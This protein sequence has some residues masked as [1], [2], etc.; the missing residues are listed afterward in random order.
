MLGEFLR[1]NSFNMRSGVVF[2]L[3][4]LASDLDA[5]ILGIVSILSLA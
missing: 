3:M 5:S 1:V 2:E 4:Y